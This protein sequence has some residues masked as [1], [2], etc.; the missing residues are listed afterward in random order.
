M[1]D[2]GLFL[3]LAGCPL[4]VLAAGSWLVWHAGKPGRELRRLR[5]LMEAERESR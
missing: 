3:Q 5:R 1:N 2:W 4:L